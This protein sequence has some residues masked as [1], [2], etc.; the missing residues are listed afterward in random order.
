MADRISTLPEAIICHILS[1][2]QTK[3]SA[4]TSILSKRWKNIW[5]SVPVLDFRPT[6]ITDATTNF[7]F[8]DFVYSVFISRDPA[9]PIKSFSLHVKY[10]CGYIN[11]TG[12]PLI[13]SFTKWLNYVLQRGV[14]H[15]TLDVATP[16]GLPLLPIS[17]FTC[18][19]L[20]VLHLTVF[21]VQYSFSSVELPLLKTLNLEFITFPED[22]DFMLLLDGCPILEKL[23][24]SNVFSNCQEDSLISSNKWKNFSLGNLIV[25]DV[26]DVDFSY[27]RFPFQALQNVRSLSIKIAKEHVRIDAIPTFH[28]LTY[29]NLTSLNYKWCILVEFLKH[30]PKLQNLSVDEAGG[31]RETWT[32]KDDKES[33]VDLEFVPQCLSLH[34]KTCHLFSFLGLQGEVLLARY[35][36]KNARVLE[37]MNIKTIGKSK[38][39]IRRCLSSF[40][41]AS[42]MCKVI[43]NRFPM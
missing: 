13:P 24:I 5:L 15:L 28:N 1:F 12:F 4:A 19:T 39:K 40:P 9:L 14:E 20:V 35:I 21:W 8:N 6:R 22:V 7:R 10:K 27:F 26:A 3:Q 43:V 30:C 41:R 17:I 29:L 37:T 33:W 34:L 25:A 2:L 18:R 42:S 31:M 16:G 11:T 32:R 23:F 36:L 38:S